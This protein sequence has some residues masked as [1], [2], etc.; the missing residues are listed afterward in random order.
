MA[1]ASKAPGLARKLLPIPSLRHSLSNV[2]FELR[3]AAI[4]HSGRARLRALRG[5]TALNLHLGCGQ[6]MRPGWVNIDLL[7]GRRRRF[8]RRD[9]TFINYDLRRGL[10]I[11]SNSCGLIYS[12][13]FFEHL[14][15]D[16]GMNLMADC[17]RALAPAGVFRLVIPDFRSVFDAYLRGDFDYFAAA[18]SMVWG[19][20][21]SD[22]GLIDM[23]NFGVYQYGEHQTIHDEQKL[24][25]ILT[26]LGFRNPRRSEF[27]P[28]IDVD[29]ELRRRYSL[30]FEAVK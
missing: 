4:T 7:L 6:D 15:P 17:Y 9:A 19:S 14:E 24:T 11:H 3:A 16:K 12:S 5:Q 1:S 29:S 25:A 21:P 10:P 8:I 26:R 28:G 2:V 23:V 13:H 27:R 20:N 18:S 22:K 30:Y